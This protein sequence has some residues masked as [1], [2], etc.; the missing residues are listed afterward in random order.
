MIVLDEDIPKSQR[1]LLE[2]WRFRPK[3]IGAHI[4]R[5]G[6]KD[7]ALIALLLR[8]RRATFFTRDAGFYD[9]TLC[10]P[11]YALTYLAV[12]KY[13]AAVFVRRV[14]RHKSL[15][16]ALK[17]MGSVLRVSRAG[18]SVWRPHATREIRLEWD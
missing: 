18:V 8:Q 2:R 14:L 1:Q 11:R 9:R 3:Q 17:R 10:H 15:N 5:R 6:L 4:G 12:D 13:E 16:T 7:D